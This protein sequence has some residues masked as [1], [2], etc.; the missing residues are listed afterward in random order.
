MH[1][2]NNQYFLNL[3]LFYKS[4]KLTSYRKRILK[5]YS[6]KIEITTSNVKTSKNS[7]ENFFFENIALKNN[8]LLSLKINIVNHS[9]DN[10][11][12][13]LFYQKLSRFVGILFLRRFNLFVDFLKIITLFSHQKA[14]L[15]TFLYML[16][17]IF[18]VLPKRKHN[19]FL[20]FLKLIFQYLITFSSTNKIS[21]LYQIKGVKFIING[22]L[23]GKTRASS[24]CIQ[25][26][27]VPI[28]SISKNIEFSKLHVY[29]IYGAFGFKI[30][31]Y[32][33]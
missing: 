11:L 7:L 23:Q 1:F 17:Q 29:T 33:S 28:Q 2:L 4:V 13:K 14:P 30:W 18:R 21:K 26:G 25:I 12:L 5:H 27:A 32:R 19:R 20:F 9:V 10:L 22:K 15:N 31:V 6:K 3:S 24:S 8:N 16:G